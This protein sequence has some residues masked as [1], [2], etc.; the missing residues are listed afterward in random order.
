METTKRLLGVEHPSMLTNM[1]NLAHTYKLEG[2]SG[3]VIELMKHV[4]ELL[5]KT[6]GSNHP[7]T[8]EATN[9]LIVW[10]RE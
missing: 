3:W 6:I 7:H 8:L 1:N 9:S 2:Q 10:S 5:T 4:V